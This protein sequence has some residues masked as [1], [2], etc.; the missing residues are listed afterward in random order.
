MANAY[1]FQQE[2]LGYRPHIINRLRA[3][4]D[5]AATLHTRL[6]NVILQ[7]NEAFLYAE[8]EKTIE[9]MLDEIFD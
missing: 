3:Q 1:L 2:V 7:L 9:E 5:D 6:D 4:S 8:E